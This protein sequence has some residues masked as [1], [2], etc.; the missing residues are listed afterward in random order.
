MKLQDLIAEYIVYSPLSRQELEQQ[1][2]QAIA[3]IKELSQQNQ[4]LKRELQNL[5]D[6]YQRT[7]AP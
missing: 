4:R 7:I 5:R 2:E 6:Y 1:L 3:E